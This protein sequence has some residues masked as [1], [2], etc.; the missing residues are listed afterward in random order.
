M[1]SYLI[2]Q[3]SGKYFKLL[4]ELSS[5]RSLPDPNEQITFLGVT[6]SGNRKLA[7]EF[8]KQSTRHKPHA[9]N[10]N[11]NK[12]HRHFRKK[13]KLDHNATPFTPSQAHKA[14]KDGK[15]STSL[16][17][18][19]LTIHQLKY[20][21]P[22]GI[23]YLCSLYNLSFQHATLSAIRKHATILP[24]L[25]SEKPKMRTLH[26]AL[27]QSSVQH[28][29]WWRSYYSNASTPSTACRRSALI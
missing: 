17:T 23:Q 12:L 11:T 2:K 10:P 14:I 8:V 22:L 15:N 9:Y 26:I 19:L 29:K 27:S 20:L 7:A 18:D 21:G 24:L 3:H 13:H 16:S 4:I 25:K 1:E 6:L 28:L 5:K